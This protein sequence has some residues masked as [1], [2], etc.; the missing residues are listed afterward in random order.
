MNEEKS[1]E[2]YKEALQGFMEIEPNADFML[3]YESD[4][5]KPVDMRSYVWYRIGKMYCYGLGTDI[6]YEK[7]YK[8]FLKSS[9]EGNKFSQ[10]SLGNRSRKGLVTGVLLVYE[11]C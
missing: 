1:L 11:V 4:Y 7:S 6:N 3:P 5:Q 10:Y 2:Y 9:K 8:W